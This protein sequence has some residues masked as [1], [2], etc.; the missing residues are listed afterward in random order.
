MGICSFV[1][2]RIFCRIRALLKPPYTQS[3]MPASNLRLR[4]NLSLCNKCWAVDVLLK[5]K[6]YLDFEVFLPELLWQVFWNL[7]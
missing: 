2:Q 7:R 4:Q 5:V 3:I 6:G 1:G